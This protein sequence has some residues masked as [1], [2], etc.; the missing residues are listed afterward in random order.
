[1]CLCMC[2]YV[3]VP[4]CSCLCLYVKYRKRKERWAVA[5][6]RGLRSLQLVCKLAFVAWSV[7]VWHRTKVPRFIILTIYLN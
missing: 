2:M 1:M 4:V 7:Y 6:F 3:C 5:I